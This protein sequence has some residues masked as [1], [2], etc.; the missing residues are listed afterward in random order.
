MTNSPR[1]G[2][3]PVSLGLVL[4]V[5]GLVL[6]LLLALVC[7]ALVGRAGRARAEVAD[8]RLRSAVHE[9]ATPLV[10]VPVRGELAAHA[11]LSEALAV[12]RR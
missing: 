3:G 4:L 1:R 7:R 12:A 2:V 9:V 11:D 5:G 8:S 6:G 10:V